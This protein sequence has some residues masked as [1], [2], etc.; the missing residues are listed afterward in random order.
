[1]QNDFCACCKVLDPFR[2]TNIEDSWEV[3]GGTPA[4]NSN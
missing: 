3:A 2:E 4:P 1:M